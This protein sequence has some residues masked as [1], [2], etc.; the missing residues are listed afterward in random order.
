MTIFG[1]GACEYFD[2]Y[3]L[4]QVINWWSFIGFFVQS[5]AVCKD[6]GDN[7]HIWNRAYLFVAKVVLSGF[8]FCALFRGLLGA[9]CV[10]LTTVVSEQWSEL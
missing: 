8:Y 7:N 4:V 3:L 9:V 1:A 5:S 2:G 6:L 10:L